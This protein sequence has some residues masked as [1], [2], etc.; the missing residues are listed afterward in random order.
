MTD[1]EKFF[2]NFFFKFIIQFGKTIIPVKME[3]EFYS[4]LSRSEV[5]DC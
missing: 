5:T 2:A 3:F 1:K 4:L